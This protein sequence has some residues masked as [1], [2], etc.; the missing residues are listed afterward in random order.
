MFPVIVGSC[1][2]LVSLDGFCSVQWETFY[3]VPAGVNCAVLSARGDT[4]H[5]WFLAPVKTDSNER[6]CVRMR[7][8][9]WSVISRE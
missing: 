7:E 6:Q 1:G 5:R 2:K 4:R 3:D 8:R 9:Q